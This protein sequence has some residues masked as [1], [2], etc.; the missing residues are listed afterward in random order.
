MAII[1]LYI[2]TT[3]NGENGG[4]FLARFDTE[5]GAASDLTLAAAQPGASFLAAT[6][7]GKV[8][9]AVNDGLV[10]NGEKTGGLSAYAIDDNHA[11]TLLNSAEMS[12][13]LCHI[14]LDNTEKWLL[15]AAYSRGTFSLWPVQADGSLGELHRTVK[16]EGHSVDERR[17]KEAHPHQTITS[18]DN[19][20]LCVADLGMDKVMIYPFDATSGTLS[21][22]DA[23]SAQLA[24]GAGPR[25]AVFHP[26]GN[27]LFVVNE[28]DNTVTAF[29]KNHNQ[30]EAIQSISTVPEGFDGSTWT[31]EILLTPDGKFLYATNRGHHSI[32]VFGVDDDGALTLLQIAATGR[33]PQHIA[34]SPCGKWLLSADR[35]EAAVSIFRINPDHGT[36]QQSGVLSDLP[37]GPMCVLFPAQSEI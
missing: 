25:H 7:N 12:G 29:R 15:G 23:T 32:A 6:S 18:P 26:S 31:A 13:V 4:I 3:A 11:L 1:P 19:R 37:D 20:S 8:L 2:G 30:Y 10:I 36:L 9:F 34:F 21:T 5:T 17:Q 14:S 35:D 28:L 27:F 22:D 33:F 16:H 24:P